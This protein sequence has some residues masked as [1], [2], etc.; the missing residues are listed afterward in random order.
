MTVKTFL[1]TLFLTLCAAVTAV[2]QTTFQ[3]G[4]Q[5]TTEDGVVS[6]K[7]YLFYYVGNNSAYVK[8][9]D[10]SFNATAGDLDATDASIFSG[11]YFRYS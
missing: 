5:I 11:N 4:T 9:S 7:P 2:A 1:T 6:G 8:A 10:N 3:E